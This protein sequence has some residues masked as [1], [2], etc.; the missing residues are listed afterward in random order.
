VSKYSELAQEALA[1]S[2]SD[3]ADVE[4]ARAWVTLAYLC[5]FMGDMVGF[6]KYLALSDSFLTSSVEQGSADMLPVGF[7]EIVKHNYA[8]F[9]SSGRQ[10]QMKSYRPKER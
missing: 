5:C 1:K 10:W 8:A 3:P 4:V 2:E 7:A 6:Q 9:S